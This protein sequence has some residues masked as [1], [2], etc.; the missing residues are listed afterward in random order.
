[1]SDPTTNAIRKGFAMSISIKNLAAGSALAIA[2]GLTSVAAQA[3]VTPNGSFSG[4]G[5]GTATTVSS[6]AW[7]AGSGTSSIN[8]GALTNQISSVATTYLGNPNNF[9]VTAGDHFSL[10][11]TVFDV[12]NGAVS[13]TLAL[14]DYIFS[15]T[16]EQVISKVNGSIGLYFTGNL[17]SDSS[18]NLTTPA[19]ADFS[20][21]LTQSAP[22]GA[23][24]VAYSID[25]P[26]N[27][28]APPSVPEPFSAALLG[29]GLV[30]LGLSSR[31][32]GAKAA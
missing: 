29:V 25:S 2:I 21:G 24:G 17:T 6:G 11:Q 19:N 5:F 22:T 23:I 31:R 16:S 13:F 27:P 14:D 10:S 12:A 1:L 3:S 4:T 7:A 28:P 32:K 8:L 9:A 26:P 18:G 15:F 20:I 30:G